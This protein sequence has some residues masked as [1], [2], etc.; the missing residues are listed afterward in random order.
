MQVLHDCC[1][2]ALWR[3]IPLMDDRGAS[4]LQLGPDGG[5][6]SALAS[7]PTERAMMRV[8]DRTLH[9]SAWHQFRVPRQAQVFNSLMP[10]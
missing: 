6:L 5:L 9:D 4:L 8:R 10:R 2:S 1:Q 7:L 3:C